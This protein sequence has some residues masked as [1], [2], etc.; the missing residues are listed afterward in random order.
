MELQYAFQYKCGLL[1]KR[2]RVNRKSSWYDHF[3]LDHEYLDSFKQ[4]FNLTGMQ[5]V[6]NIKASFKS[7]QQ[8]CEGVYR[9]VRVQ[10]VG[11]KI[12]LSA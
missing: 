3:F 5:L 8:A 4:Q 7:C 9:F 12:A 11:I 10:I 6:H 1:G 2:K